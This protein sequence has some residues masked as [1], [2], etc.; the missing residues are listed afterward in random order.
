MRNF[1]CLSGQLVKIL[2]NI[3][4]LFL[5]NVTPVVFHRSASFRLWVSWLSSRALGG[6][7]LMYS[8]PSPKIN[9]TDDN[10]E[11]LSTLQ[12]MLYKLLKYHIIQFANPDCQTVSLPYETV[13]KRNLGFSICDCNTVIANCH[14]AT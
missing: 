1:S 12:W 10:K 5:I 9:L 3:W 4:A 13:K 6:R 8:R 14:L 7:F 2:C 11:F